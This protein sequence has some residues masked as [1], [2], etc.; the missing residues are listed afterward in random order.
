MAHPIIIFLV[1][2]GDHFIIFMA[3]GC[4]DTN[5]NIAYDKCAYIYSSIRNSLR[6]IDRVKLVCLNKLIYLNMFFL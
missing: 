3:R 2:N 1:V 6:L 4:S 5:A